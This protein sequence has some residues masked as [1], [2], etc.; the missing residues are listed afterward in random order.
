MRPV[1]SR[2]NSVVI[3]SGTLSPLGL[4]PRLLGFRPAAIAR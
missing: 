1:F 2:F 3:T 4:Y